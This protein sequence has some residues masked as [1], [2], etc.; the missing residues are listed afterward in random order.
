[1]I[2]T[3]LF[4]VVLNTGIYFHRSMTRA[5]VYRFSGRGDG[6]S[7]VG[8]KLNWDTFSFTHF[9]FGLVLLGTGIVM[10]ALQ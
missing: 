8:L 10:L 3:P 7:H 5:P 2:T 9:P 6:L 4:V 1:M